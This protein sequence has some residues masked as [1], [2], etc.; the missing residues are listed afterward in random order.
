MRHNRFAA[1]AYSGVGDALPRGEI[2]IVLVTSSTAIR[3]I[4]GHL[5]ID[6]ACGEVFTHALLMTM[7][8][9]HSIA[10]RLHQEGGVVLLI[11]QISRHAIL[12]DEVRL[13]P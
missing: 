6:V 3:P 9:V 7:P 10:I 12:T 8:C 4:G 2:I 5:E 1:G 11:G 13:T